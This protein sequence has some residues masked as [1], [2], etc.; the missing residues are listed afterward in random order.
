MKIKNKFLKKVIYYTLLPFVVAWLSICWCIMK[1]G[2]GI[3]V[4]GDWMSG[5][6]W[7]GHNWTEDV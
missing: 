3:Y 4:F 5:W 6:R 1:A 7:D 2:H